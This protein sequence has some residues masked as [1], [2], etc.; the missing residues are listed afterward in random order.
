MSGTSSTIGAASG[1][2]RPT[3][4]SKA[5]AT[6]TENKTEFHAGKRKREALGEVAIAENK[7]AGAPVKGKEKEVLDG[8]VLKPRNIAV[9]Q[10]LRTVVSRQT[11][12][13]KTIVV[14]VAAKR[15]EEKDATQN[16]RAMVVDPPPTVPLPNIATRRSNLSTKIPSGVGR[17]HVGSQSSRTKIAE[18]YEQP[19]QKK[20][21]T[22]SPSPEEDTRAISEARGLA[23][24]KARHL[25]L[26]IEIQA[27][28]NEVEHDP[29]N[30][31]W[32]DLD[33]EDND[34]PLMV[35]EYVQEIFTYMKKLEVIQF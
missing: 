29:E 11:T 17:T 25:R 31:P 1:V 2:A 19:V 13:T 30:S 33:T 8:V 7:P 32:D 23:E 34:D 16:D 12:T 27:F 6:V 9:R 14:D 21:R 18:E 5:K 20:R 24:E 3:L 22:S 10:P 26:L 15:L 35:S 4:A 28:A